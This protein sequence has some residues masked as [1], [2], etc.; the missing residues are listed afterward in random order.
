MSDWSEMSGPSAG[1]SAPLS[2]P[3]WTRPFGVTTPRVDALVPKQAD[4]YAASW[5]YSSPKVEVE[6]R[7]K[8][9]ESDGDP[10]I[11]AAYEAGY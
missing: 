11:W 5:D 9:S 4:G 3:D 10:T 6:D 7:A 1:G 8:R 2:T